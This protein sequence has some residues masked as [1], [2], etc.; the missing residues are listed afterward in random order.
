[1]R[2]RW[3]PITESA[4][5]NAI[6]EGALSMHGMAQGRMERAKKEGGGWVEKGL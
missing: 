6:T 2:P 1:M 4:G 5:K 3:T